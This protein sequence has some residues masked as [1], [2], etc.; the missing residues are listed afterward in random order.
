[1]KLWKCK[2]FD[3]AHHN[4]SMKVGTDAILLG[5]WVAKGDYKRILDVG[6]GSGIIALCV[7]QR[8]PEAEVMAIDIHSDS[9]KEANANFQRNDWSSRMQAKEVALQSLETESFDL[10]ISNPPYFAAKAGSLSP[11][12]S[13]MH[14]RHNHSLDLTEL[15]NHA[16]NRLNEGGKLAIVIPFD[17]EFETQ[18]SGLVEVE[19]TVVYGKEGKQAERLLL[20][21]EKGAY[22]QS[23]QISELI[24]R[25]QDHSYSID[26]I[27]LTKDFYL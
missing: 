19:R 10:I 25:K 6:T 12:A 22:N 13:R 9:V 17:A 5:A 26:Y 24:I 14:A 1:M 18:D 2:Q 11:K 27:A 4:S 23:H 20:L 16:S 21:F 8:F 3:V 7:A 15:L